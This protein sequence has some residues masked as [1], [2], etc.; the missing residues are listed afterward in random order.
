RRRA[1]Q[2]RVLRAALR[3]LPRAHP[4]SRGPHH[5]HQAR[6]ERLSPMRIAIAGEAP[7]ELAPIRR[8]IRRAIRPYGLPLDAEMQVAFISDEDMR[9]LNKQLRR[10]HRATDVLSFGE[11]SP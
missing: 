3:G 9:A 7:C 5:P 8:A 6:R 1:H 11:A 2:G 10:V 4:V